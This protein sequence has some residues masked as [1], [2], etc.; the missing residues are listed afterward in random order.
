MAVVD[1][2]I[3]SSEG[4]YSAR[5]TLIFLLGRDIRDSDI[6]RDVPTSLQ[7][8]FSKSRQMSCMRLSSAG[9][10]DPLRIDP[11]TIPENRI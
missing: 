4:C 2:N 8:L 11:S 1:K 3:K 10:A 7:H 5:F 9:P 6:I